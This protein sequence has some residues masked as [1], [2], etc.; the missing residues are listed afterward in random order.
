MKCVRKEPAEAIAWNRNNEIDVM[1]FIAHHIDGANNYGKRIKLILSHLGFC[2][3]KVDGY[4][5]I[6]NGFLEF[7]TNEEFDK[8]YKQL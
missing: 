2:P 8:I 7:Y 4:F 3:I 6:D 1:K 5:V